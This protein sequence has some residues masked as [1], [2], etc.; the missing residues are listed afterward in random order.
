V[1]GR[2]KVATLIVAIAL[3]LPAGCISR[4]APHDAVIAAGLAKLQASC[5]GFF[6]DLQ[7]NAGTPDAVWELHAAWYDATR[8]EIAALRGRAESYSLKNDPTVDAL[9]LLD[10]SVNELE[11]A[12]LQ[13]LS[14][15]EIPVLRTLFDSQLRMLVQLEAAKQPAPAEVSP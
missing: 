12:H 10:H 4:V 9:E 11:K 14:S 8:A 13:G 15:G 2:G 6:D 5:N 1:S 7:R 3:V